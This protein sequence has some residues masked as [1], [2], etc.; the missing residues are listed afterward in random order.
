MGPRLGA[1]RGGEDGGKERPQRG[2]ALVHRGPGPAGPLRLAPP[3]LRRGPLC[4]RTRRSA[5]QGAAPATGAAAPRAAPSRPPRAAGGR[6]PAPRTGLGAGLPIQR[7]AGGLAL[8]AGRAGAPLMQ[9]DEGRARAGRGEPTDLR[10]GKGFEAREKAAWTLTP[11]ELLAFE[12]QIVIPK[13]SGGAWMSS[14]NPVHRRAPARGLDASPGIIY[15]KAPR[16]ASGGR[17]GV[18]PYREWRTGEVAE[19]GQDH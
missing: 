15:P 5:L 4:A 2:R 3:H 9:R 17:T 10:R 13:A 14:S 16:S 11:V 6:D 1:W 7:G 12:K 19:R 18:R 8:T